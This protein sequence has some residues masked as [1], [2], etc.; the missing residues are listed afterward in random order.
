MALRNPPSMLDPGQA[1]TGVSA[2][3]IVWTD[4]QCTLVTPLY[5]GGI[6]AG[7][8]DEAMPIRASA[9]R[10]QLR[11][12][13][14]LLAK[15]RHGVSGE[16]LRRRE[17]AL[18]GG[19]GDPVQA[20]KV[21]VRIDA[22]QKPVI[23]PWAQ[24][25]RNP[26]GGWKVLPTPE[27][28]AEAP[29]AL[30]SAQGKRPGAPDSQ[31]PKRLV[32]PGLNWTLRVGVQVPKDA[33]E[34]LRVDLKERLPEALRWWASFGGAGARTRRGLGAVQ[35]QGIAS[36]TS[37]EAEAAGCKLQLANSASYDAGAAWISAVDKLKDFRQKPGLARNPGSTANRPGRSRWPEP[38]AIR[39][40]T[41]QHRIK[42]DGTS[43]A[44]RKGMPEIFPRAAFGLPIVFHFQGEGTD[45]RPDPQ[46][47]TLEPATV[48]NG[49]RAERMASPLILRP[50]FDGKK[51]KA[52]ALLLPL[53]PPTD[54]VLLQGRGSVGSAHVDPKDAT[55]ATFLA[56]NNP[57]NRR[58]SD[59]LEAF[60]HYFAKG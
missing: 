46:D 23:E 47:V 1:L 56:P 24:F 9:I 45:K 3:G 34:E 59:A 52:A 38:E 2:A 29:Y 37:A 30:F 16:A 35:V 25:E 14:R 57:M 8:V 36:V 10:G 41:G 5:G 53:N 51:W 32:K 13:W 60:L 58:G 21:W 19:L 17:F 11:F 28:W 55:E 48:V 18:W 20:S 40:I 15:H 12:W 50:Y 39:A 33:G 27:K 31:E 26:N 7:K 54:L 44:P 4:Y 49:E 6:S 22:V 42:G 43:F